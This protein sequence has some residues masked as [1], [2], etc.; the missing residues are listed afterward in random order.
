MLL[1]ILCAGGCEFGKRRTPSKTEASQEFNFGQ[2]LGMSPTL[3]LA[4]ASR[5]P[6]L[7]T[8]PGI[9][10]NERQWSAP[11][12][13]GQALAAG[14][15]APF[16]L[17]MDKMGQSR[18]TYLDHGNIQQTIFDA[19][20]GTW[21]E[22]AS[23]GANTLASSVESVIFNAN[24]WYVLS[25]SF[26]TLMA[27]GPSV[28][29]STVATAADLSS[30]LFGPTFVPYQA[31]SMAM[32]LQRSS[33]ATASL[34]YRIFDGKTWGNASIVKP[35]N[36]KGSV[37]AYAVYTD[38]QHNLH[39]VWIEGQVTGQGV[40]GPIAMYT[41]S[42]ASDWSFG[43]AIKIQDLRGNTPGALLAETNEITGE[44]VVAWSENSDTETW[45][46]TG[47][48]AV[49]GA[50]VKIVQDTDRPPFPSA[51]DSRGSLGFELT[52]V[53]ERANDGSVITTW[54]YTSSGWQNT[55]AVSGTAMNS[56][57]TAMNA[58]GEMVLVW[59]EDGADGY[60]SIFAKRFD[61]K[62]W[63]ANETL[64][65]GDSD[66]QGMG[67]AITVLSD[68]SFLVVWTRIHSGQSGKERD[69]QYSRLL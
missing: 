19:G 7:L 27:Q 47:K 40:V 6:H 3:V 20:A 52:T 2:W 67:P 15:D 1:P 58:A 53:G 66:A 18:L 46:M 11:Q 24:D 17:V 31:G 48:G 45:A 25:S 50:P 60:G 59:Q 29:M 14:V 51:L 65:K 41:L 26:N 43:P 32:W 35:Q 61:G 39:I 12:A 10:I 44:T 68:G 13:V 56:P 55:G 23:G 33:D 54:R 5:D 21:K 49:F 30:P 28:V 57:A 42:I 34:G 38:D 9:S 63:R 62:A 8:L 64:V 4:D 36:A 69:I 37:E 22:S 16:S